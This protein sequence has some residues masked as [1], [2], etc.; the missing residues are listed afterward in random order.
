MAAFRFAATW[1][2]HVRK[3][4]K[5]EMDKLRKDFLE[6]YGG[7]RRKTAIKRLPENGLSQEKILERV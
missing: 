3:E 1:V 4:I 5:T 7:Y 2:P 6:K